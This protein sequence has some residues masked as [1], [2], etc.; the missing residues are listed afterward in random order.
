[1]LNV[2]NT[3]HGEGVSGKLRFISLLWRHN[4]R[5]GVSNHQ[6][7][8]CFSTIYSGA[9][10]RKHQISASR[11]FMRGI[12]WSPVNSAYKWPITRRLFPF[13]D[14]IVTCDWAVTCQINWQY[15][16]TC[17]LRRSI[18]LQFFW[19]VDTRP[20]L[21]FLF[22]FNS[23]FY[24]CIIIVTFTWCIWYISCSCWQSY[25]TLSELMF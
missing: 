21:P 1:M 5:D 8:D 10:Q 23:T 25:I 18:V 7:H 19:R 3:A 24:L 14:V 4:G 12:H 9:N 16:L 13:D 2:N 15:L 17:A 22:F 6:P 11:A 20:I